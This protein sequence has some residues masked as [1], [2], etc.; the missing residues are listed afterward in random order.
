M[1]EAVGAV[2]PCAMSR[3]QQWRLGVS[4][5]MYCGTWG[6]LWWLAVV[7]WGSV[8]GYALHTSHPLNGGKSSDGSGV[9]YVVFEACRATKH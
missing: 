1:S 3:D 5:V 4:C 6:R 7:D 2:G 8:C 9:L